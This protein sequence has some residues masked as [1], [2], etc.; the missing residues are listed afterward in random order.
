[1]AIRELPSTLY[2][3]TVKG[4]RSTVAHI[5]YFPRR[6]ASGEANSIP[7]ATADLEELESQSPFSS[8]DYAS[9]KIQAYDPIKRTQ[10]RKRELPRSRYVAG[11]CRRNVCIELR[12]LDINIDLQDTIV[13]LFILTSLHPVRIL[14][15]ESLCRALSLTLASS[16]PTSQ[17]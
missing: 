16:K 4:S 6:Y 8:N 11:C 17:Q 12:S 9:E 2:R 13:D 10:A 15:L 7:D 14:P 3:L 5:S 1:M